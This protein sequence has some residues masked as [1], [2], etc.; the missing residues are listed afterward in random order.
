MLRT[1]RKV[2]GTTFANNGN[3]VVR[4]R[5][6]VISP[7]NHVSVVIPQRMRRAR[8]AWR[9]RGICF[10][11]WLGPATARGKDSDRLPAH[12]V[13]RLCAV[14]RGDGGT[15][16]RRSPETAFGLHGEE[17]SASSLKEE[18]EPLQSSQGRAA[19]KGCRAPRSRSPAYERT[20]QTDSPLLR[21]FV[22][23]DHTQNVY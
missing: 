6:S 1:P 17:L 16:G 21:D 4:A 11:I 20:E 9:F 12:A 22:S 23:S 3:V 2:S 19:S 7:G 8:L 15:R 13:P 5:P 14:H 18:R 10:L